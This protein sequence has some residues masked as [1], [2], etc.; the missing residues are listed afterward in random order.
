M[1]LGLRVCRFR[2]EAT[3]LGGLSF[4]RLWLGLTPDREDCSE[5]LVACVVTVIDY[6]PWSLSC[7]LLTYSHMKPLCCCLL[8]Q[9]LNYCSLFSCWINSYRFSL[10][11]RSVLRQRADSFMLMQPVP[12]LLWRGSPE[13]WWIWQ[14]TTTVWGPELRVGF[15]VPWIHNTERMT[16]SSWSHRMSLAMRLCCLCY[17]S[18]E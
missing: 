6:Q 15:H 1:C 7:S 11:V 4:E 2:S 5:E 3:R 13:L 9:E 17:P 16:T 8:N 12:L 10:P 14:R 18:S